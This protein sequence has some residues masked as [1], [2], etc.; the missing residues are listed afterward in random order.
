M[1]IRFNIFAKQ[2]LKNGKLNPNKLFI[3]SAAI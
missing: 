3:K 2:F 1:L